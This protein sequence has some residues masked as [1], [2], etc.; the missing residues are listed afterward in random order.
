MGPAEEVLGPTRSFWGLGHPAARCRGGAG[1]PRDPIAMAPAVT[2]SPTLSHPTPP[3]YTHGLGRAS[4]P[5]WGS[6]HP[7]RHCSFR[8]L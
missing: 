1:L 6:T 7:R 5:L 8:A 2:I 3:P 4:P